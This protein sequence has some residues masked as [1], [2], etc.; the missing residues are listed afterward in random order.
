MTIPDDFPRER[1]P[2]VVPGVET[3]VGVVL[4]RG[5]YVLQS[6]E[7]RAERYRICDDLAHRLLPKALS[8]AAKHPGHTSAETLER[9]R[10]AVGGKRMG[11]A[12]RTS[13][14]YAA[15]FIWSEN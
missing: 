5:R 7:Q 14:A 4:S 8:D 10:K 6:E 15:A 2:P 13:L 12:R 1:M 3:K 11:V 9:V